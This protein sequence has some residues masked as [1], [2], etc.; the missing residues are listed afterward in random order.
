MDPIN[1]QIQKTI[2]LRFGYAIIGLCSN[3]AII[4]KTEIL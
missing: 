4:A 1:L 3:K 2:P